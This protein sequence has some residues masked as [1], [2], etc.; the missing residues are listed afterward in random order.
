MD[1]LCAYLTACSDGDIRKLII[2]IPPGFSKSMIV[3]VF[4][5]AWEWGPLGLASM[6]YLCFSYSQR[7][8]IRDNT[9]FLCIIS[10]PLYREYWG[11]VYRV[12][13]ESVILVSNDATG[14]KLAGSIGSGATGHRGDA[15]LLDDPN[16]VSE[17]ESRAVMETTNTWLR[18]TMPDRLNNIV[19]GRI[20]LI[21][22]RTAENDATGT[23]LEYGVDYEHLR[24]PMLYD[25]SFPRFYSSIGFEDPRTEDGELAFPERFPEHAVESMK[26]EKGSFAWSS[27][28]QQSPAPR[29]GGI[30]KSKWWNLYPEGGEKFDEEG[31]PLRKM[32]YPVLEITVASLDT[33]Y[34]E[35]ET[36][37]YSAM[38]IWGV[39]RKDGAPKVMLMYAWKE[40][41]ELHDLVTKVQKVCRDYKVDRLLI[42]NKASGISVSQ[43]LFRLFDKEDFG[44]DMITPS[45]DKMSRMISISHLFE[46]GLIYAPDRAWSQMVIDHVGSFPK[47]NLDIPDTVSQALK[48]LRDSN[49]TLRNTEY[50]ESYDESCTIRKDADTPIYDC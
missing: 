25:S 7:L 22:Q 2:N 4:F 39:W 11:D 41:L 14:W 16:N 12:T 8:T 10:D 5:P 43:E 20:I 40:R 17:S 32:E 21:Q 24:I 34:T 47:G 15:I 33:A 38:T 13:Q 44:I 30:I 42:E 3:N 23:L 18:E 19:T 28:Y 26:K 36:N 6:R 50:L 35:K 46:N 37:D 48:Y 29:G 1:C 45:G 49:F 31:R 27:Q 9:R